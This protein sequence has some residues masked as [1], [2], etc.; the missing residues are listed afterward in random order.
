[1]SRAPLAITPM[2]DLELDIH[3][4]SF[5]VSEAEGPCFMCGHPSNLIEI[6]FGAHAHVSC[7]EKAWAEVLKPPEAPK[8]PGEDIGD[9]M[10]RL[11][12]PH[13][14]SEPALIPCCEHC[15]CPEG[16][17]HDD[18]CRFGCSDEA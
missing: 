11:T 5:L 10:R 17:G 2:A 7:A 14:R 3:G 9:V 6:N 1:M 13:L 18:T 8:P 4:S 15:Q 12:P 16:G